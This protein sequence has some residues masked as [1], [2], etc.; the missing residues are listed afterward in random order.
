MLK[1]KTAKSALRFAA[2]ALVALALGACAQS[3]G[4]V[5]VSVGADFA[6]TA[7]ARDYAALYVPYAMMATA[8]YAE[9]DDRN[10]RKCPD[11][12]LLRHARAGLSDTD[13]DYRKTVS[14]WIQY[15]NGHGWQCRFG[16]YNLSCPPQMRDCKPVGGLEFNVWRRM[17][18]G[19]CREAVI[20]FR[21][22]DRH[23]A[24][25]WLS[26][27]RWLY[28]L[29]PKFDQYA[30]VQYHI[31]SI[32]AHVAANGCQGALFITTG[33]SLGGG[34]AQ[35]AAYADGNGLIRYVYAFDPSPVTGFFDV[36]ALVLKKSTA[37]LGVDRAYE[38]G[39]ILALP[40]LII[41]NIYPPAPC[42][43]RVRTVRFNLLT[44]LG[45]AQHSISDL[46]KKLRETASERG[47][48]PRRV[49]DRTAARGCKGG[50]LLVMTPPA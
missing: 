13:A 1:V 9:K 27:F 21:G 5:A 17:Q 42:N 18:G 26:N 47:A 38:Q 45:I 25:D 41:E 16:V 46:T 50:P 23:D 33:H 36:S 19:Q 39:E 24:G 20:A 37:G 29:N 7:Q 14:G 15:L 6:A 28:R 49:D 31:S 3:H 12:G 30:Q 22:T 4:E 10:S 44:G 48:S 2:L 40:R 8:A 43:P 11:A 32:V 34:L 35:Q